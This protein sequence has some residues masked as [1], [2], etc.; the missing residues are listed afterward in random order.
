MITIRTH[1]FK[2]ARPEAN[3]YFDVS[4]LKN[5]WRNEAIRNAEAG[6]RH[7]LIA[8]FMNEQTSFKKFVDIIYDLCLMLYIQYPNDHHMIA[9][10]CSAGEYRSPAVANQVAYQLECAGVEVKLIKS[11]NAKV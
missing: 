2:Y 9:I 4:Y 3:Y 10:C 6:D 1:G 5:P 11:D 8:E 7:R